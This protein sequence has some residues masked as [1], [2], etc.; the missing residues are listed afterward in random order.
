MRGPAR[1]AVLGAGIMGSSTALH[2]A[3]ESVHVSLFDR[4]AVPFSGSSRWIEGKIHLGFLY[5]ADGTLRTARAVLPGGLDFRDQFEELTGTPLDP[6]ITPEDDIYLVHRDSVVGPEAARGYLDDVARL[7][8]QHPG[9]GR[10]LADVSQAGVAP[11]SPTE[12]ER[13]ADPSL[14]AA[15][16][17]VPERSVDANF[18]GD[19]FVRALEAEDAVELALDRTVTGVSPADGDRDDRWFVHAGGERHG[20]FDAVVNALWDGRPKVDRTIGH[21]PDVD[22][23]HRYRVSLF[24]RTVRDLDSP[25][26]GLVIGP[27]GDVKNYNGRDH[28][29]SWYP[30]GLLAQAESIDPPS[31]PKLPDEGRERIADAVFREL[32]AIMPWVW[33]IER[34][35]TGVAV[36]GGWVYSQ[37]RGLLDDPSAGVHRR[38]RLGISRVGSY[39][40]VDTGKFSVAPTLAR[41]LARTIVGRP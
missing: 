22:P 40:S 23:Q 29:L 35:A 30:V 5:S 6:A 41:A 38:N 27:F 7:V 8:R 16:Y 36:E 18:V 4:E 20:P 21:Q 19:A 14:V 13:L 34:A 24:V 28:Y 12:L 10:Y 11:L 3:R 31:K 25:S 2:L 26:A 1:A 9:A 37:G 32:G 17:R 15:G 33:D 39:F